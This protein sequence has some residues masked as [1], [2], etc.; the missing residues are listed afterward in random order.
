MI[1]RIHNL[2]FNWISEEVYCVKG[3]DFADRD[4]QRAVIHRE[5]WTLTIILRNE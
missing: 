3:N 4:R 5:H 1:T 2:E